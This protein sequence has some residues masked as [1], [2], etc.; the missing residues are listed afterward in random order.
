MPSAMINAT[1][2]QRIV[3]VEFNTANKQVHSSD[4]ITLKEAAQLLN[5]DLSTISHWVGQELPEVTIHTSRRRYT[6]RS[7]CQAYKR[8]LELSKRAG[9]R[10]LSLQLPILNNTT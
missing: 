1:I 3:R 10:V 4:L 2:R 9:L 7:A 8:E 5:R 6:L